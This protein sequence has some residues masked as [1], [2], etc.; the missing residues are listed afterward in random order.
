MNPDQH[1]PTE[2]DDSEDDH[3]TEQD[4]LEQ[5]QAVGIEFVDEFVIVKGDPVDGPIVARGYATH[6][7]A[8]EAIAERED[9]DQCSIKQIRTQ[10]PGSPSVA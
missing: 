4:A 1:E 10:K 3:L 6:E 7:A 8:E 2:V 9:A 5:A